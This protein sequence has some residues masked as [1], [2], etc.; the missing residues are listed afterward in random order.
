MNPFL[1]AVLA[2]GMALGGCA[3]APIEELLAAGAAVLVQRHTS[4]IPGASDPTWHCPAESAN[5][6]AGARVGLRR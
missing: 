3:G 1:A 4:S 2:F 5:P 6:S